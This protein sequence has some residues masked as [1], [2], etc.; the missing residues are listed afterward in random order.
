MLP[1]TFGSLPIGARFRIHGLDWTFMKIQGRWS[2]GDR[3]NYPSM[4]FLGHYNSI[5]T[6]G[7][8]WIF[9]DSRTVFPV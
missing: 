2:F 8:R 5:A 6:Y 7:G 4:P 9:E 1:D 3:P